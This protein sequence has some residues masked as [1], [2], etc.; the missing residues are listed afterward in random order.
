MTTIHMRREI[1]WTDRLLL[2]MLA[3]V[4][5]HTGFGQT[6]TRVPSVTV[7][8][9]IEKTKKDGRSENSLILYV[10]LSETH[11]NRPNLRKVFRELGEK[12]A[13]GALLIRVFSDKEMLIWHDRGSE[14]NFGYTVTEKAAKAEEDFYRTA[15]PPSNG[16]FSAF[17]SRTL[18]REAFYFSPTKQSGP[19][20]I[21]II[22]D[23][24][25]FVAGDDSLFDATKTG[26]IDAVKWLVTNGQSVNVIDKDG[27]T[28]L[29]WAVWLYQNDIARILIAACAN[30]NWNG[31]DGNLPLMN[32]VAAGNYEGVKLLLESGANPNLANRA[33]VTPLMT[34][35]E[36]CDP[37]ITRVLI[38]NGAIRNV[39]D[40]NGKSV[41]EYA[42][43]SQAIRG[44]LVN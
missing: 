10:F 11:F 34:S 9:S 36:S 27:N 42:C 7:P 31:R 30:P 33:G 37:E 39:R 29:S 18:T 6:Q 23:N 14:V 32:A 5:V 22:R 19:I 3:L 15:M 21:E 28:P 26:Y 8:Y 24:R 17:Y 2:I 44:L 12:Y 43:K 41:Y 1:R 35:A 20:A 40:K 4:F 25:A 13:N 16:Y 38:V